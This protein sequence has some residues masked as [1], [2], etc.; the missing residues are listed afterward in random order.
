MQKKQTIAVVGG[1]MSGIAACLELA[2][3]GKFEITLL[4]KENQLGG[5]S[6]WFQWEDVTWDKFYHVMLSSDHETLEFISDLGLHEKLFWKETKSGFYGKGQLVSMSTALDFL[7][8]PFMS[9]WQKFRMGLGIIYSSRLN[10]ASK[11]DKIFAREWL[12]RIFG[13]RVYENI[14]E[15][16]LRSK[17]GEAR[18]QT[19]ALFIWAT[20]RRL[21][22][23]R[24]GQSK[25]EMMGHVQG[26]YHSILSAAGQKLSEVGITVK[27]GEP[28]QQIS[29]ASPYTVV[30]T[31]GEY[32][33]DQVLLT[34]DCPSILNIL[35]PAPSAYWDNLAAINYLSVYCVVLITS[36]KLSPYYV[37]NLLDKELPFTGVIEA[38]NVVS[39][40]ETGGKHIV[41]LPKYAPA[42]DP[43]HG[44]TDDQ[45]IA[46]FTR[47]LKRM[48]PDLDDTQILHRALH[49][50]RYVQPVQTLE[51]QQNL[52]RFQTPMPGLHIVNTAMII[53]STL[54]N[55]NSLTLARQCV[56]NICSSSMRQ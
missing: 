52:P 39:P 42:D 11:L 9:L 35:Q 2:K 5:L 20:I 47:H 26:G 45:I 32:Q 21:Y 15:P 4:E 24:Q 3:T 28:V 50:A 48:F 22:G 16:L 14:W 36:R 37:I 18:E 55:N 27:T 44:Q 33:F 6:T 12:T 53:N 54:N 30:T 17:L 41:F 23:A 49:K 51:Y 40:E 8:F 31:K 10:D 38:T 43:I 34:I 7:R 46:D 13:R 1:G 19:S 29:S 56:E 25:K